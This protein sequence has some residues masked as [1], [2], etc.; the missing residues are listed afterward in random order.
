MKQTLL[1]MLALASFGLALGLLTP[2]GLAQPAGY[3]TQPKLVPGL[4]ASGLML[5]D[6]TVTLD[7]LTMI[8]FTDRVLYQATRTSRDE[9]FSNVQPLGTNINTRADGYAPAPGPALTADGLVLVFARG[10][11]SANYWDQT[12]L[13][14]ARRTS[15]TEPFGAAAPLPDAI[16]QYT[17]F[18][19]HLSPDGLLLLFASRRPGGQGDEDIWVATRPSLNNPFG[20]PVNFNDFFPGS[21]VNSQYEEVAPWLSTDRRVLFFADLDLGD[22]SERPGSLGGPD[23]WVATRPDTNSPFGQPRNLNALGLGSTVNSA[24]WEGWPCLSRNWPAP[25]SKLYF[26]HWVG[27]GP[28][29][30]EIWE[31]E[32]VPFQWFQVATAPANTPPA[33][34]GAAMVYDE[35]REVVVLHGGRNASGQTIG[36]TWEWDGNTWTRVATNGPKVFLHNMAYDA[37]RHVTVLYGG[38]KVS[39]TYIHEPDTWEW[40]GQTWQ[41]ISTGAGDPLVLAGLVYDP[42]RK[43]VIRH[44]GLYNDGVVYT[45]TATLEWDGQVWTN[46]AAGSFRRAG[47]IAVYDSVRKGTVCFGGSSTGPGY[48]LSDTW[49]FDGVQWN[50]VG[51]NGPPGRIL[52]GFTFDSHRGVGILYGGWDE[53]ATIFNDTWEWDGAQWT[54]QGVQGPGPRWIHQALA[55]DPKRRKVVLF[56]GDTASGVTINDTWE[57]GSPPLQLTGLERQPDS[58]LKIQWTG[59]APPYQL[60]SRTNLTAGDWQDEGAPTDQTSATVQPDGT[61]KFFRVLSQ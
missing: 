36:D 58:S 46:I 20:D 40:D 28:L 17:S 35:K 2:Q 49:A 19:P 26:G 9:P 57:Y 43:K 32:W 54:Q 60:Q 44:G 4:P 21:Q 7:E 56:G 8:Y 13:F 41:K 38:R 22:N 51:T 14:E 47:Q 52:H 3:F 27:S 53:G 37:W 33:R 15:V 23:I 34:T 39:G 50:L 25:G 1:R 61:A 12:R 5:L 59:E 24:Q 45:N 55:Y 42:E 31:A 10:P 16:N 29:N 6:A 30:T 11:S 48:K 18:T